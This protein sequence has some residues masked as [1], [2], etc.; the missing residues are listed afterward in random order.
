MLCPVQPKSR[1]VAV[2]ACQTFNNV[3]MVLQAA[4]R[5][6]PDIMQAIEYLDLASLDMVRDM[7]PQT[8]YPFSEDY[9]HYVLIEVA[10][11][12]DAYDTDSSAGSSSDYSAEMGENERLFSFIESIEDQILVSH[13]A[14]SEGKSIE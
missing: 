7:N 8:V 2:V 9:H 10:T 3:Q 12:V 13:L 5:Q 11:T 4:K 1:T 6:L 14:R